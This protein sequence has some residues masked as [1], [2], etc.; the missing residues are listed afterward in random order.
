MVLVLS[1]SRGTGGD[2]AVGCLLS[3]HTVDLGHEVPTS[4]PAFL[5]Q[6]PACSFAA[7][8]AL[9]S[10][11]IISEGKVGDPYGT[12]PSQASAVLPSVL[13]QQPEIGHPALCWGPCAGWHHGSK[14]G[15]HCWSSPSLHW[16]EKLLKTSNTSTTC[17]HRT[18]TG[19]GAKT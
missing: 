16:W 11:E 15:P 13:L 9:A 1:Q 7:L 2:S 18:Q 12:P 17:H 5:S 4:H 10:K 19:V 3:G 8:G 6:G 14:N